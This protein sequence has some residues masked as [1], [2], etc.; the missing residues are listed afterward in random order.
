VEPS[1]NSGLR[2]VAAA[3]FAVVVAITAWHTM[4]RPAEQASVASAPAAEQTPSDM[5]APA[6]ADAAAAPGMAVTE[7][8]PSAATPAPAEPA[9]AAPPAET[10]PSADVKPHADA[11]PPVE[12]PHVADA[13]P[14]EAAPA[15][16]VSGPK[17]ANIAPDK[18]PRMAAEPRER[19]TPKTRKPTTDQT[20][21][22]VRRLQTQLMVGALSCGRPRMQANYN[23][24]VSKF[25]HALKA[26]GRQ[27]KAYFAS[28]YG[29]R[30]TSEMDTYLTKLSNE[31]S[32]VS[33]RN[34]EFCER[35]DGLFDTVLA[36]RTNEIETFA[37]RYM[38]QAV[39]SRGF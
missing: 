38:V 8:P 7:A 3:T 15:P 35:T 11:A 10:M 9:V 30:G 27:L 32:L 25:D 29:A 39:A 31:L 21:I 24:F 17:Y 1:F 18:S 22:H 26:N 28:R 19:S 14:A 12:A 33:M 16:T 2:I 36:L 20:V 34:H 13:A 23:T 37:D 5:A 4:H 6:T